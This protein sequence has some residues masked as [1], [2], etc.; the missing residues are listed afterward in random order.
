L[1]DASPQPMWIF[2][3][4]TLEFLA[5]NDAAVRHYGYSRDEFLG[6]TIMDIRPAEE[7]PGPPIGHQTSRPE[8]AFTR[9]QRKDGTVIDMELVS[10]ELELDGRRARLVLAT[11]ISERTRTRAALHHSQEQL[12][13]A[14]RLDAATHPGTAAPGTEDG[15][16]RPPGRRHRA[17]LQ[18]HPDYHPRL[19]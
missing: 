9:H 8:A 4:E 6:M 13:Q 19:R 15:S 1:F 2:D 14:Q 5:V 11:D 7:P 16:D 18:Q 10:H 12:R 17:R 3:V